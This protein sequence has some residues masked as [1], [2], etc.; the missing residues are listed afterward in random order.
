MRVV[1]GPSPQ[2]LLLILL[3]SVGPLGGCGDGG[4]SALGPEPAATEILH[5]SWSTGIRTS[6]WSDGYQAANHSIVADPTGS[7]RGQVL[8]AQHTDNNGASFL[9]HWIHGP[10]VTNSTGEVFL[11]TWIFVPANFDAT[12]Y[13]KMLIIKG[14]RTDNLYSSFGQAG[15]ASNGTNFFESYVSFGAPGH[16]DAGVH[17]YTYHTDMPGNFGHIASTQ[18][19]AAANRSPTP[20]AWHKFEFWLKQNE[21]GQAN[22]EQRI[23]VDD[24]LIL[25]WTGLRFRTSTIL[26]A[27]CV[28]VTFSSSGNSGQVWYVDDVYVFD[29]RPPGVADWS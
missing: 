23:W 7:G 12:D 26:Q 22:G 15:V 21:V 27:N 11:R 4:P 14:N 13:A 1:F 24:L 17:F 5:E 9:A 16:G 19:A 2:L 3:L 6:V 8:R 20:G 28:V 29:R 25:E 18:A 10:G